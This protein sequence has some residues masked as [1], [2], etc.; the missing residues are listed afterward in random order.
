MDHD[1]R[2]SK[3]NQNPS[4]ELADDINLWIQNGLEAAERPSFHNPPASLGSWRMRMGRG[5]SLLGCL[6]NRSLF[7][8][9]T[10]HHT[11][12]F[13]SLSPQVGKQVFMLPEEH[14]N[15]AAAC[16][17]SGAAHA[18]MQMARGLPSQEYIRKLDGLW[19]LDRH[20][21][22]SM[23]SFCEV[24][25]LNWWQRKA[26]KTIRYLRVCCLVQPICGGQMYMAD[27]NL[28]KWDSYTPC[29]LSCFL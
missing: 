5:S 10:H 28:F 17:A 6:H 23:D 12:L 25:E 13:Q 4:V 7:S 2:S 26:A 14:C 9:I 21:S 20:V 29:E 27:A 15:S 1:A 19:K 11:R 18:W 22:D 24:M 8:C 3:L 16:S